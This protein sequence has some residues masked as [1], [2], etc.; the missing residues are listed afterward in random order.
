VLPL[1]KIYKA[2]A[3]ETPTTQTGLRFPDDLLNKLKYIAWFERETFTDKVISMTEAEIK[4]FE[5]KNGAITDDQIK[6]ALKK[7]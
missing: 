1:K 4:S 2:M 3:A 5:K 7:K 6:K